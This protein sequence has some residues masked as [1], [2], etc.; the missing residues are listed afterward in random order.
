[1]NP[2][3]DEIRIGTVGELLVALRL[4]QFVVQAAPPI[5]DSGNDLIAVK[6]DVFRAIQVKTT[7]SSIFSLRRLPRLFHVVALVQLVGEGNA[8]Y[9]DQ[10]RIFLLEKKQIDRSSYRIEVLSEYEMNEHRVNSL[11]DTEPRAGAHPAVSAQP[12]T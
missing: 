11:F 4:L 1:M 7:Q 2:I 10:S 12:V 6:G 3:S 5:K 9:L 8:I